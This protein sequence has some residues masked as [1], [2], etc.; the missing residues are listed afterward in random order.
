M[1]IR[2]DDDGEGGRQ[3]ASLQM[4][5]QSRHTHTLPPKNR[6]A[7]AFWNMLLRYLFLQPLVNVGK[8]GCT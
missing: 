5:I 6:T 1:I 3:T 7:H 4:Y 8:L 2:A